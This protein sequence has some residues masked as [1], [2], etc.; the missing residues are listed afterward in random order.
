MAQAEWEAPLVETGLVEAGTL[1]PHRKA[2]GSRRRIR[3]IA[4]GDD[5][6]DDDEDGRTWT[7]DD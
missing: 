4:E 5:G 1:E 3:A 2:K 6:D 7:C